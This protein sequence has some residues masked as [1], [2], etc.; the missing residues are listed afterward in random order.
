[1]ATINKELSY[2]FYYDS[3]SELE[4]EELYWELGIDPKQ[5]EVDWDTVVP[6]FF[7]MRWEQMDDS[8]REA[9][10]SFAY[11][12]IGEIYPEELV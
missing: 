5:E 7:E 6:N 11:E 2:Q 10:T 3:L 12:H 1:M 8:D 9:Y 4:P